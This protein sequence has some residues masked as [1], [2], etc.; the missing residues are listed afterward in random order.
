MD[1]SKSS[2][3]SAVS[4]QE[5]GQGQARDGCWPALPCFRNCSLG[6]SASSACLEGALPGLRR[7]VVL[8]LGRDNG[9]ALRVSVVQLF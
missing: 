4:A 5:M 1:P 2:C 8:G 3:E 9:D 6:D 7:E